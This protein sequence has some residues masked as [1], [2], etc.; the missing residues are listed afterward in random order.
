MDLSLDVIDTL[1][2]TSNARRTCNQV[3][4]Y[5]P[6]Q[7]LINPKSF[8]PTGHI[9]IWDVRKEGKMNESVRSNVH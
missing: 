4:S 6:K 3:K 1:E 9:Y 2:L 7:S 5:N 8:H